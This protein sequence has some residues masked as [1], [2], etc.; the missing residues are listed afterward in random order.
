MWQEKNNQLYKKFT[1]DNFKQAINFINE[2]AEV[3]ESLNHH[4]RITNVYN[5]VEIWLYTHE[6]SDTITQKDR[7]LAQSI[8]QITD[9]KEMVRYD[10]AKLFA[11][12]GSRGNPGPSASGYAILDSDDN[13]IAKRGIYIGETTN[14]QAEY[15][16]V[17][18]GLEH[19]QK[20]GIKHLD[21]FL[22]SQL[23]VNQVNGIYRVKNQE[24]LPIFLNLKDMANRFE[25]ISFTHVPRAMNSLADSMVNE[26][27]DAELKI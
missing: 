4:P 23:V 11:D 20:L 14:N 18:F 8:D 25:A 7:D 16:A 26:A 9:S 17:V 10:H 15:R 24:L 6:A 1:F 21:V 3:S 2:V 19:A 22:D 12:G 13:V 5:V 27:L